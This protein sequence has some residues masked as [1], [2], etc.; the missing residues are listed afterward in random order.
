VSFEIKSHHKALSARTSLQLLAYNLRFPGQIFDGQVGLHQNY[1]RDFDPATGKYWESDPICLKG[2]I[3]TYAY[4]RDTLCPTMIP[5]V[6]MQARF[7]AR[8]TAKTG[9]MRSYL[10]QLTR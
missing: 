1:F 6:L 9:T 5:R 3:N 7:N 2:D 10:L 4:V 8:G